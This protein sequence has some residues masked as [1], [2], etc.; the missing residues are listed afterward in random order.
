ML[1]LDGVAGDG[2]ET[3]LELFT[4]YNHDLW[5]AHVFAY[6]VAVPLIW[7]IVAPSSTLLKRI[8]GLILGGLLVWLGMVFQALYATDIS[9]T[10]GSAYAALF[11][12]GG[13]SMMRAGLR[14]RL[15]LSDRPGRI[16]RLVG[17]TAIVYA[18][19]VYP[20][21]GY[22]FGHGWPEAPLFGMA[23]CPTVIA[24]FGV[25]ALSHPSPRHLWILPITW[26]LLA[27]GPAVQRGVW[28]DVGMVVFGAG[29]LVAAVL[30]ARSGRHASHSLR[31]PGPNADADVA[32]P[33]L[34]TPP[35]AQSEPSRSEPGV[36]RRA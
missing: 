22:A 2:P 16:S 17:V 6:L 18:L 8:P 10:L 15:M 30:D 27:T 32:I 11:V 4:R 3:L 28:E 5:P 36:R 9:R 26:T 20:M 25:L 12:V 13:L 24:V 1:V 31:L 14:G 19:L 33:P 29:A 23:P 35:N 34:A 21:L 7:A